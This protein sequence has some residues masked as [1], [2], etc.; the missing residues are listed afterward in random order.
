MEYMCS[1]VIFPK[2]NLFRKNLELQLLYYI[3]IKKS[4]YVLKEITV[5]H[6]FQNETNLS[7]ENTLT[8]PLTKVCSLPAV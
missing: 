2:Q 4:S 8:F 7:A 3:A 1:A 5:T 6:L